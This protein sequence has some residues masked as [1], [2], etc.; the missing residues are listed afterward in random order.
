MDIEFIFTRFNGQR[1]YVVGKVTDFYEG[2][3]EV[4]VDSIYDIET[5]TPVVL[6]P[7]EIPWLEDEMLELA[8]EAAA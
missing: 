4:Q 5:D 8:A 1:V 6:E 3:G 7:S 2:G